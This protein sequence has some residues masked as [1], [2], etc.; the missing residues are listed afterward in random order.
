MHLLILLSFGQIGLSSVVELAFVYIYS[1]ASYAKHLW[2]G[3]FRDIY[4]F[5][6]SQ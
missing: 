3:V 1:L 4:N 5:P 6:L 2:P